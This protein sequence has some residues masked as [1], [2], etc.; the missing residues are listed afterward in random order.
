MPAPSKKKKPLEE[1]IPPE[2]ELWYKIL[3]VFPFIFLP[4]VAL[5]GLLLSVVM[6]YLT[7]VKPR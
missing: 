2:P 5:I 6:P 3:T 4:I 7:G 1:E